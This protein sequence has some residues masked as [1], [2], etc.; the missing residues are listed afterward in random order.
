[1]AALR[2]RLLRRPG[3]WAVLDR[4]THRG[5]PTCIGFRLHHDLDILIERGEE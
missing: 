3:N 2:G 5:L 1:M 4:Y